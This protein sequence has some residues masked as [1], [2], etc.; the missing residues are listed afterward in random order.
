MSTSPRFVTAP[1]GVTVAWGEAGCSFFL[2]FGTVLDVVPGS[3]LETA[4]G[5][6]NRS[7]VISVSDPRR[8]LD[9]GGPNLSKAALA[10]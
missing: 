10:N 3:A 6:G 7:A 9:G 8:S 4:I 5:S 1:A 2:R